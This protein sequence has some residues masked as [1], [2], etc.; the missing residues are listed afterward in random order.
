M[1]HSDK[2]SLQTHHTLFSHSNH[3]SSQR[4]FKVA[5]F[6]WLGLIRIK[7]VQ[8]R[9]NAPKAT[10]LLGGHCQCCQRNAL[11]SIPRHKGT[12]GLQSFPCQLSLKTWKDIWDVLFICT[13]HTPSLNTDRQNQVHPQAQAKPIQVFLCCSLLIYSKKCE[14]HLCL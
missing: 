14:R 13:V 4:D 3:R 1:R 9:A 11:K 5:P 7:S 10:S 8:A 12:P 6:V 2:R